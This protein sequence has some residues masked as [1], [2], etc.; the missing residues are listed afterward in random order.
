[1][2]IIQEINCINDDNFKKY[3][4]IIGFDNDNCKN[5]QVGLSELNLVGWRI[6]VSKV[7]DKSVSRLGCHPYSIESFQPITGVTLLCVAPY[8]EP[9]LCELFILDQAVYIN[10]KVW[11]A[12]LCLTE[13]SF[14]TICENAVM[15]SE[16]YNLET[17][18][19]VGV[20]VNGV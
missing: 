20:F 5:F 9:K 18:I 14:L 8:D 7:I 17:E 12:T 4:G 6:A 15:E 3:G 16:F 19:K 13:C 11:H 2:S 10:K 1:V